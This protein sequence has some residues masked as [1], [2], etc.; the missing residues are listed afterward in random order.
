MQTLKTILTLIAVILGA[1]VVLAAIGLI[2]S[3]LAYILILG[4]IC[5][6]GYIAFK[7]FTKSDGKQIA[8]PDPKKEFEKV[9]RLLD[10]YKRK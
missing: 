9:R 2:Y 7:L 8:A 5:L 10:E 3:L 1:L 4:V 6:G